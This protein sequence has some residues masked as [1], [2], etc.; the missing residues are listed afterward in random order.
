MNK[1][2]TTEKAI[3]ITKGSAEL[4]HLHIP[5]NPDVLITP[6]LWV[7]NEH[8]Q[9][10]KASKG[11]HPWSKEPLQKALKLRGYTAKRLKHIVIRSNVF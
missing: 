8:L 7:E 4:L 3:T 6:E 1:Y 9:Q 5:Y 11:N 2:A 10:W